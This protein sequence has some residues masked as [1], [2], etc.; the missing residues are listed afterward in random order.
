MR[1]LEM[2]LKKEGYFT[3]RILE[4]TDLTE[5]KIVDLG[6]N[7]EDLEGHEFVLIEID[8]FRNFKIENGQVIPT[9]NFFV[10]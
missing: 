9:G 10:Q 3:D 4:L 8:V 7:I 1:T 2:E 5:N 6:T